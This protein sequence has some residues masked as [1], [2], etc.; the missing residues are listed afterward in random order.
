MGAKDA[1]GIFFDDCVV[2]NL[3]RDDDN[4]HDK[5]LLHIDTTFCKRDL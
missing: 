3:S 1:E 2:T 4:T 5:S